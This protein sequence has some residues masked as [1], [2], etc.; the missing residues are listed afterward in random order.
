MRSLTAACRSTLASTAFAIACLTVGPAASSKMAVRPTN[1]RPAQNRQPPC[2]DARLI[3]GNSSAVT[4]SR[5]NSS[6]GVGNTSPHFMQSL[7]II[8]WDSEPRRHLASWSR[9][10]PISSSFWTASSASAACRD[11]MTNCWSLANSASLTAISLSTRS[12]VTI[13]R[14]YSSNAA[15]SADSGTSPAAA[16][17]RTGLMFCTSW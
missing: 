13:A 9:G 6:G 4:L 5:C 8:R 14:G 16:E 7:R 10:I 3:S 17:Y 11:T 1:C 15:L 2:G 12:R